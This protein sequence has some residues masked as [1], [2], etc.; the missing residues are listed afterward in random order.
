V[1]QPVKALGDK[2]GHLSI[3]PTTHTVEEN[4]TCKLSSDIQIQNM[5]FSSLH[6]YNKIIGRQRQE[7]LWEASLVYRES[8]RAV[9]DTQSSCLKKKKK[10]KR[11]GGRKYTY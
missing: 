5:A 11:G 2:P 8:F 7:D 4:S 10:K 1:T 3:V 6:T 9:R